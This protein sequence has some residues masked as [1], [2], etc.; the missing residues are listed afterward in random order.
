M[1]ASNM[2]GLSTFSHVQVVGLRVDVQASVRQASA[3][4]GQIIC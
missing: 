3:G 1:L 4:V 2:D